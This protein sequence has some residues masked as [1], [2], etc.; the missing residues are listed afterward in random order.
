MLFTDENSLLIKINDKTNE[1]SFE[2]D[3]IR[4]YEFIAKVENGELVIYNGEVIVQ[5]PKIDTNN[6]LALTSQHGE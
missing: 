1:V 3:N 4:R 2:I 5:H 6:P